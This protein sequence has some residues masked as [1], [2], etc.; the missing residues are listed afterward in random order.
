MKPGAD[1]AKSADARSAA[2]PATKDNLRTLPLPELE[3]NL[4]SPPDGLTQT[5]ATA[6]DRVRPERAKALLVQRDNGK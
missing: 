5:E 3:K 2:K 1:P 6:A 4:Q